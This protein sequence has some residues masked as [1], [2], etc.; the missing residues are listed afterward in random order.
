[1]LVRSFAQDILHLLDP[2]GSHLFY[3][4]F[5]SGLVWSRTLTDQLFT[6]E[7]LLLR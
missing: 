1:M 7:D 2:S 3:R 5:V 4:V 6:R